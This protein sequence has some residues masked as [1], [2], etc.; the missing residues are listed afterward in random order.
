MNE[1]AAPLTPQELEIMKVVWQADSAVRRY[2][3]QP[4][5]INWGPVSVQAQVDID[6]KL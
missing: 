3:Y 5:L 4:T 6:F 2:R 1:A